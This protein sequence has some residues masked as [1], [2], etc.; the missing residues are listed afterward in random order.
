[1]ADGPPVTAWTD[2]IY[3]LLLLGSVDCFCYSNKLSLNEY[4]DS[5]ID[6]HSLIKFY[7]IFW[8]STH[9][10]FNLPF[11][12]PERVIL[13]LVLNYIYVSLTC[14][15]SLHVGP[16]H[17]GCIERRKETMW[18]ERKRGNMTRP[19][20]WSVTSRDVRFWWQRQLITAGS[21]ISQL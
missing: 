9:C 20:L 13:A 5:E 3:D 8:G 1:M 7:F 19:F 18:G 10:V 15:F 21:A 14:I 12:Q 17:Q 2:L 16:S 6:E 4:E 11:F